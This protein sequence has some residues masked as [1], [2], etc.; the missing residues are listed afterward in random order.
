MAIFIEK[1]GSELK[2]RVEVVSKKAM[3]TNILAKNW[4]TYILN[5]LDAKL[6]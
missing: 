1:Q 4:E 3:K 5:K 2:T 6:R